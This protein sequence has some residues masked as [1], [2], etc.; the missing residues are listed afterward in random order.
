LLFDK[1]IAELQ[2]YRGN[3]GLGDAGLTDDEAE[4]A[5]DDFLEA[6]NI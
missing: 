5:V 2:E 1:W 4:Q 6:N 3:M